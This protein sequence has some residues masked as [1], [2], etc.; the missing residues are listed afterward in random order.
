MNRAQK[1]AW[2][3]L[4]GGF[5]SVSLMGLM[6]YYLLLGPTSEKL[7][8]LRI[9]VGVLL[10][11]WGLAS[12]VFIVFFFRKKQSNAE[13]EADERDRQ[14]SKKAIQ[15][16]FV[17]ICILMFFATALPMWLYGLDSSI[18]TVALPLINMA[19]FLAALTIYNAV[20]LILYRTEGGACDF[21]VDCFRGRFGLDYRKL[22]ARK[23]VQHLDSVGAACSGSSFQS[24]FSTEGRG[25]R[26]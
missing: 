21:G 20:V 6:A 4:I 10:G 8:Q 12:M 11:V 19:V 3:N 5:I 9:A 2:M 24:V 26:V 22:L 14:I 16:A 13:P 17:S 18:P 15:V 7:G 1:I 23:R 25:G